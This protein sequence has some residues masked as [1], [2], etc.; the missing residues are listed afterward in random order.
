MEEE[1]EYICDSCGEVI[2]VPVDVTAGTSQEY[3]EDCPVCCSP[4]LIR[5]EIG[6]DG[7]VRASGSPEQDRF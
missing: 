2:V 4:N 5:I 6:R 7:A 1:T 3:V